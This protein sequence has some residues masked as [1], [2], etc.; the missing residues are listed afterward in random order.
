[1]PPTD[2]RL[3]AEGRIVELT[4]DPLPEGDYQLVI[5]A[6]QVTDRAGNAL[7]TADLVR[8]FTLAIVSNAWLN[9]SGGA[10]EVPTNWSRGVVPTDADDVSITLPGTYTIT[11]NSSVALRSLTLGAVTGAQTLVSD[12][13]LRLAEDSAVQA[14]GVL[15]LSSNA[16]LTLGGQL[17]VDG[18]FEKSGGI[19]TGDGEL[20]VAQD[21]ELLLNGSAVVNVAVS[22][23]GML[24]VKSFDNVL[25]GALTT[26]VGSLLIIDAAP[27]S[28]SLTI[29][30]GFINRGTIRLTKTGTASN[31]VSFPLCS[32]P[33]APS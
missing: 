13:N 12:F 17:R 16:N 8:S 28:A 33:A 3:R 1:M 22:N 25:N 19:A 21:G 26:A 5:A 7:G 2:V 27:T 32:S 30:A 18:K 9:A 11:I 4:Y 6:S 29:A 24:L 14:H 20:I 31:S 15:N 23:E 10:W